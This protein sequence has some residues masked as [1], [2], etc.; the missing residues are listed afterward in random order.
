MDA[1]GGMMH[2]VV[3]GIV[4]ALHVGGVE[5]KLVVGV[6]ADRLE[7]RQAPEQHGRAG[8]AAC[9]IQ[10]LAEEENGAQCGEARVVATRHHAAFLPQ[11]ACRHTGQL[12][13]A[14]GLRTRG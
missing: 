9:T 8:R 2:V 7:V 1:R 10:S 14:C 11:H 13:K 6:V 12:T 5:G 3:K 4:P